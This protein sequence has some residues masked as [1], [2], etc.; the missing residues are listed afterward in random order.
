[1]ASIAEVHGHD[2]A[3]G[4]GDLDVSVALAMPANVPA[5]ASIVVAI[6]GI[7]PEEEGFDVCISVSD[8]AGN[9][10]TLATGD[11]VDP[12]C[13]G[14]TIL[15][16]FAYSNISNPISSGQH[17]TVAASIDPSRGG[18]PSTPPLFDPYP[19]GPF[20]FAMALILEG[21]DPISP[22]LSSQTWADYLILNGIDPAHYPMPMPGTGSGLIIGTH[23]TQETDGATGYGSTWT[24]V[25]STA[26][27]A[28]AN[29]AMNIVA[30]GRPTAANAC[31]T[32]QFTACHAEAQGTG[33]WKVVD[34]ADAVWS[35]A[36]GANVID[37]SFYWAHSGTLLVP[38]TEA[39]SEPPGPPPG[40]PD[41]CA[42]PVDCPPSPTP[43]GGVTNPLPGDCANG[44]DGWT[45]DTS[46]Q[47]SEAG[48]VSAGISAYGEFRCWMNY[49]MQDDKGDL[50]TS[51]NRARDESRTAGTKAQALLA[52]GD[53]TSG[54]FLSDFETALDACTGDL[55]AILDDLKT[56]APHAYPALSDDAKKLEDQTNRTA[57]D[58]AGVTSDRLKAIVSASYQPVLDKLATD[59]AA[60]LHEI[61]FDGQRIIF[62][63]CGS[64]LD[65]ILSIWTGDAADYS[66]FTLVASNDDDAFGGCPRTFESSVELEVQAGTVY[67]VRIATKDST[68]TGV[69]KLNYGP[70]D[71]VYTSTT[72]AGNTEPPPAAPSPFGRRGPMGVAIGVDDGGGTPNVTT[73]TDEDGRSVTQDCQT[74][75]SGGTAEVTIG[76]IAWG[77]DPA[78]A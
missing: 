35:W 34:G 37:D 44:T 63:T 17:V 76:P 49:Q 73:V 11:S 27:F 55:D 48:E 61:P 72:D 22:D 67:H 25:G 77:E 41:G 16:G 57:I 68:P 69:V 47:D 51:A 38:I 39:G 74:V 31:D 26:G 28:A 64:N 52:A 78:T 23:V 53:A 75:F 70:A 14:N 43:T 20:L 13:A 19:G 5:G 50:R 29:P 7:G 32:P 62:N 42:N 65:T 36:Q 1:M 59:L 54:T 46:G 56:Y 66:D 2:V 8:A 33:W 18:W 9:S 40:H 6:A 45:C 15:F 24:A 4:S 12:N 71:V 58:D 60:A 3:A 30:F 10:W 21:Y